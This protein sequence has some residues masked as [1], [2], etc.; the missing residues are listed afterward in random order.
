M[1]YGTTVSAQFD[2]LYLLCDTNAECWS[3]KYNFFFFFDIALQGGIDR[4]P[5]RD[6]FN[7]DTGNKGPPPDVG[8]MTHSTEWRGYNPSS[9][10]P[11][12]WI[13]CDVFVCNVN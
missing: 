7:A 1:L 13:E 10:F 2:K 4:K 12:F 5:E 6:N 8:G 3:L 11:G 9:F